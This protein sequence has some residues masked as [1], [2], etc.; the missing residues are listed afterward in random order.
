MRDSLSEYS[1]RIAIFTRRAAEVRRAAATFFFILISVAPV[2]AGTTE[3]KSPADLPHSELGQ[4]PN[5][6][7]IKMRLA[8]Y[9]CSGAYMHA[10][11]QVIDGAKRYVGDRSTKGG[12]LALVLDIDETS[13]SNLEQIEADDFGFVSGGPCVDLPSG[14][15][16]FDAWISLAKST[17]LEPT[18]E[19]FNLAKA[20]HV[21]IF[22]ITSRTENLRQVT[23]ANLR[24]AGYAGWADLILRPVGDK[25]GVQDFKTSGRKKITDQGYTIIANVGDQYSDLCGGFAERT[26]KLPN[27]FYFISPLQGAN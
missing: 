1:G 21:Q 2:L 19:L 25:S 10:F 22:F 24:S 15:C 6:D 12:K 9:A 7:G 27:P 16:G 8:Y 23:E 26:Y 13:L 11:E 5:I 17:V 20:N 4:P 3:C 14:P 18:L